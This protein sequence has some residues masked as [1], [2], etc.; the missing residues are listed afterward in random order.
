MLQGKKRNGKNLEVDEALRILSSEDDSFYDKLAD[1]SL[2]S[3]EK[4][5]LLRTR[6]ELT[7]PVTRTFYFSAATEHTETTLTYE[8][9]CYSEN[10]N[11][12]SQPVGFRVRVNR[13]SIDPFEDWK[14]RSDIAKWLTTNEPIRTDTN[15]HLYRQALSL[16]LFH[17]KENRPSSRDI[18]RILERKIDRCSFDAMVF[19]RDLPPRFETAGMTSHMTSFVTF[20]A[21]IF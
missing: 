7:T 9:S 16:D 14:G 20:L 6:E 10:G 13:Q 8:L 18:K 12:V 21:K 4:Q 17:Q 1:I 15:H 19:V 2:T 5:A 11:I 3:S